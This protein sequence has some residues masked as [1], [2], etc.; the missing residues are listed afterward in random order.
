MMNRKHILMI[1]GAA[2][3]AV[4]ALSACASDKAL[5]GPIAE[6]GFAHLAPWTFNVARVDLTSA[7]QSPMQAPN[8]EHRIPTSPER[9]MLDWAKARLHAQGVTASAASAV[10]VIEDASVIETKLDQTKGFKG[11]FITEPTERYEAKAVASLKLVNPADSSSGS[12]RASAMRSI[13]IREDATLAEREQA[14]ADLVEKL[15]ADFNTQMEMQI[16]D[17]L[18]GWIA[19]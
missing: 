15:M 1:T 19:P 11:L 6:V 3:G 2:L 14:W 17:H 4:M 5:P 7:Y 12:V 13:E 18:A 8:A 9:A 16:R 10:F